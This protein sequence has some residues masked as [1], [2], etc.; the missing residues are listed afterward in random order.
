MLLSD[1]LGGVN[2][3]IQ[4]IFL[5][6]SIKPFILHIELLY[7][8]QISIIRS[9]RPNFLQSLLGFCYRYVGVFF[10]VATFVALVVMIWVKHDGKHIGHHVLDAFIIGVTIIV[11][12]IPEVS[13]REKWI[14]I[15]RETIRAEGGGVGRGDTRMNL[16]P[17]S[18]GL[19][20]FFI[21]WITLCRGGGF[22]HFA[23]LGN[24]FGLY[25]ES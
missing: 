22:H 14:M 20:L 3:E 17:M 11:V 23:V 13:E 18:L 7:P 15:K 21:T 2:L 25:F 19:S 10:A 24:V 5:W 4:C 9:Y 12:A 8:A 16:N 1:G 6:N